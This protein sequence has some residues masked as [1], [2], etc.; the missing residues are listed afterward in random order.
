MNGEQQT[1]QVS[2]PQQSPQESTISSPSAAK[3]SLKLRAIGV[4][5]VTVFCRQLST[6][7]DV[8]IPLLKCLQI[9]YQRT[10]HEKLQAV[11]L[12]L[13]QDI[14]QGHSFSTALEKFPNI[15][16]PFFMRSTFFM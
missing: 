9:L 11:I 3:F 14:E 15:F 4:N 12:Q 5:A 10:S 1:T 2:A 8:G 6:L 16:S 7:V 13:S